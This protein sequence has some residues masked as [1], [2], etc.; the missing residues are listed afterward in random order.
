MLIRIHAASLNYRDWHLLTGEPRFMRLFVG[1]RR[2]KQSILGVDIAGT[3]A[4]VGDQVTEYS[5]GDHVFGRSENGACAEYVAVA[6]DQLAA[7]PVGTTFE[8]ASTLGVA[9]LTALQALRDKGRLERG[10]HVLVKGASG[11]VGTF[12]VQIAKAMGAEV[13]AV[14]STHKVDLV[15]SIGADHVI[16]YTNENI[17]DRDLDE[18]QR[19]DLI[20][21][22]AGNES[23]AACRRLLKQSGTY[24][25][26]GGPKGRWLGPIPHVLRATTL[27]LFVSQRLVS[28]DAQSNESDRGHLRDL[29]ESGTITPVI[30]RTYA[31][32]EGAEA[33][34]HVGD[35]HA[36]GKIVVIP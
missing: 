26:I 7:M 19:Y 16:D 10:Q 15:R 34:R 27:S 13:T 21:D 28:M 25:L 14:C 30:D 31:L 17:T 35:G 9:A 18:Q 20:L 12:A 36:A 32:S 1:L 29:L 8:Q 2:P 24:V 33:L 5:P 3:V 6:S 22:I 11:G 23:P 4:A